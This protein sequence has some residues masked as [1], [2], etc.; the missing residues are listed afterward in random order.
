MAE[1]E[2]ITL[3]ALYPCTLRN[4]KKGMIF[5]EVKDDDKIISEELVYDQK[6]MGKDVLTGGVYTVECE[7]HEDGGL[8][9]YPGTR[10][11]IQ[12][13]ENET[14][15][16]EWAAQ[17]KAFNIAAA[18]ESVIKNEKKR[19]LIEESIGPLRKVYLRM[20]AMQQ[21]ALE[22][23]VLMALRKKPKANE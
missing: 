7:R 22:T 4:G 18:T 8:T 12:R 11:W 21:R 13:W 6:G 9:V 17:A 3:V 10:Q 5:K 1:K 23:A 16:L 15:L 14:E 19:D 20:P 2:T